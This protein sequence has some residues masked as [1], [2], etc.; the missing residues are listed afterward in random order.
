M[1]R[2]QI[3]GRVARKRQL[4]EASN[5]PAKVPRTNSGSAPTLGWNSD[6]DEDEEIA[7]PPGWYLVCFDYS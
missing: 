6:T 5:P 7:N 2:A 4:A 3:E 1:N